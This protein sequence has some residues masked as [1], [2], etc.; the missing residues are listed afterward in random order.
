VDGVSGPTAA[1]VLVVEDDADTRAVL[2]AAL[3]ELDVVVLAAADGVEAQRRARTERPD[4]VLLDV[5]SPA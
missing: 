4:L 3:E 1:R 2:T 5:G